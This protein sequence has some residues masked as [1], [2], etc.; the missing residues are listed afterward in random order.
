ME[1]NTKIAAMYGLVPAF[2]FL[3]RDLLSFLMNSPGEVQNWKGVPKAF[4]REAM[5]GVIPAAIAG[6][7]TKADFT[8]WVN[9]GLEQEF[10]DHVSYFEQGGMCAR[11]NYIK[12]QA[13]TEELGRLKGLIQAPNCLVS[14]AL[15]DLLALELWL[16]SFFGSASGGT[17]PP[18]RP[19]RERRFLE[20]ASA[21]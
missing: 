11:R 3:D 12:Q 21:R 8:G 18:E 1:W 10:Q 16:N 2:P 9:T 17:C 14:W 13:V 7:R 6:R 4:L 15:T 5:G 20:H 19:E